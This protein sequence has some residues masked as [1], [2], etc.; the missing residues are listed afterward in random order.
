MIIMK[1]D[2]YSINHYKDSIFGSDDTQ[3]KIDEDLTFLNLSITKILGKTIICLDQLL[4]LLQRFLYHGQWR[5]YYL[6]IK[7]FCLQRTYRVFSIFHRMKSKYT[8]K[9]SVDF[10]EYIVIL[11]SARDQ[12]IYF[13]LHHL[14]TIHSSTMLPQ[15]EKIGQFFFDTPCYFLLLDDHVRRK[16]EESCS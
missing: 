6:A 8:V 2:I 4:H 10:I 5:D 16:K 9:T 1:K 14:F 11:I 3:K 13:I 7:P 12:N 15:R